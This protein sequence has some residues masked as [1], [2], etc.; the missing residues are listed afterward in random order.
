MKP[1]ISII[2]P[3]YNNECYF[4]NAVNS[5]LS[6][7]FENFE[8][9]IVDD[10]STDN[11]P[12]IAD[13]FASKDKRVRVIH[14]ENQWIYAS[15]NNGAE[16]AVGEYVYV[17]NS[18]DAFQPGALKIMADIA[19]KYNPDVIWTKV[20]IHRCDKNQEI[21]EYN[22]NNFNDGV[23]TNCFFE[24][25]QDVRNNFIYFYKMKLSVNQANLYRTSLMRK[26]TCRNDIYGADF[27]FNLSIAN[28]IQSVYVCSAPV[29]IHFH[30]NIADMNA[31]VRKYYGYEH[32]MF[33]EF[34]TGFV[35]IFQNWNIWN[36]EIEETL[37]SMRLKNL[38]N[39]CRY[40]MLYSNL[41]SEE[42]IK[43]IFYESVDEVVYNCA[44]KSERIEEMESRVLS[45]CN[46]L[47]SNEVLDS[48]NEFYF[49]YEMLEALLRYEKTDEDMQKIK[50]G[51]YRKNNP[52]NIG[53]SFYYKLLKG[54]NNV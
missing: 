1:F 32:K 30:Y 7:S 49:V 20:M 25:T 39:E 14:Q 43:K 26:H 17:L 40:C 42:K 31:S 54:I 24:N 8:L 23:K 18:D 45:V 37:S 38:T 50:D 48:G 3:V 28:D 29:Y 46:E 35:E 13:E 10:G 16:K 22:F 44:L 21:T 4:P 11:T 15:L 9:I 47:F 19:Q 27:L 41:T 2:M 34:Y 51:V 36:E 52:Y 5:V 33:N 6:Q 12:K 53:K